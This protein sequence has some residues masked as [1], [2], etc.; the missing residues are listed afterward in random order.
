[1]S[2]ADAYLSKQQSII[3]H[4]P[5][6][7][8]EALCYS[9]IIPSCNEE[10]FLRVLDSL[11][12]CDRPAGAVEVIV[13]VNAA[14]HAVKE[15]RDINQ[16]T[17]LKIE[18]WRRTHPEDR[19]RFYVFSAN[20]LLQRHAGVG[21]A[22]KIGMDEA[23]WRFNRI[24]KPGGLIVSLDADCLCDRDYLTEIEKYLV[25]YPQ[26]SGF[27]VYFE[28]PVSGHE[29]PERIYQGIVQYELH[30]RYYI[31]ALRYAGFPYAFHTV[32]SCYAVKATSYVKQGGMNRKKSGEDFYFLHKI[33]PLGHFREINSTCVIPSPRESGRVPFG[34]LPLREAIQ[35]SLRASSPVLR[36][37]HR[38]ALRPGC[39]PL[40]CPTC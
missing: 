12:Q 27:N 29:F 6:L 1:M 28:H 35:L 18:N 31:Q 30:L 16:N 15:V 4:I 22:R 39:A 32:G 3:P 19:F 21:L 33:I 5:E 23:V 37:S 2:F 24:G 11:W 10:N 9:I 36:V 17:L 20:D 25:R 13:V 38:S 7:P 26:A 14:D 8:S 34:T 40:P